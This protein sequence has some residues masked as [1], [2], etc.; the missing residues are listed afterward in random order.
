MIAGVLVFAFFAVLWAAAGILLRIARRVR[1]EP[2]PLPDNVTELPLWH[3]RR[4]PFDYE[5]DDP[6]FARRIDG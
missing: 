6:F 4:R 1:P 3:Q 2:P 5:R